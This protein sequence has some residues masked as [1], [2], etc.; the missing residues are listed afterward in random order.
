M[1]IF[2]LL[3]LF[4]LCCIFNSSK[5]K[6]DKYYDLFTL[7]C[8]FRI[9]WFQGYFLKIGDKEIANLGAVVEVVLTIYALYL[10][11][12][13]NIT[14]KESYLKI[15]IFFA[16]VNILG[17]FLEIAFPYDGLLLPEQTKG[18]DWDALVSG[19]CNM[20]H[21]YPTISDYI[22]P[23]ASL[24]QFGLNVIIFKNV[25]NEEKFIYSFMRVIKL[26]KFG[27]YYGLF[28]FFCKNVIGNL[29]LT[30]DISSILVGVNEVSV[31]TKAFMKNG[32]YTLQGLTREPSHFN[33]FLFSF[34]LLTMLGDA[35]L[36]NNSKY[37]KMKTYGSVSTFIA[38]F[39]LLFSGGFSAVWYLWVL[40]M[41]YIVLKFNNKKIKI[42]YL[43]MKF[44]L[45][46]LLLLS[47][48]GVLI[49]VILQNDYFYNRIQ[50]AFVIFDY[51]ID[52]DSAAGIAIMMG[53]SEGAG[54]TVARFFSS[55]VGVLVFLDRPLFGLGYS[56]QFMHNFSIYFL[57]N[58]GIIGVL[59][60][61]RLMASSDCCSRKFDMLLLFTV[62]IIGG[63]PITI[64]PLGLS[65]H[66]L[67]F[68]EATPL[69]KKR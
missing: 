47:L 11:F 17:I 64:A 57:A 46:F 12:I 58:M 66:W 60:M 40:F 24:I 20:Y 67:L 50:D 33:C 49:Y 34:L 69:Y 35:V 43:G 56:L 19:K 48:L 25:Y 45:S 30:Y 9:Y 44:I 13:K 10:L 63:I 68:F 55:Y 21:Y 4:V 31:Y 65:M 7:A 38:V 1:P 26:I 5:S 29:T 8:V 61:Y 22:K 28:E 2:S 51:I 54:S 23:Y 6:I 27:V 16:A 62:F 59:S 36:K 18:L 3:L 41:S 32:L 52:A 39:L 42:N 37:V 53:N 15:F 14:I